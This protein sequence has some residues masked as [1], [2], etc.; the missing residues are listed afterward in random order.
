V[1]S[2]TWRIPLA[3]VVAD[4]REHVA[5]RAGASAAVASLLS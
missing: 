4:P 3:V 1:S 5:W 2:E